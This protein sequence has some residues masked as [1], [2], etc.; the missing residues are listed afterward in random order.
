MNYI[1]I[2]FKDGQP[3]PSS[4]RKM[5]PRENALISAVAPHVL[6]GLVAGALP[7]EHL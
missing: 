6:A 2:C 4:L 5:N 1:F 7:R 3:F